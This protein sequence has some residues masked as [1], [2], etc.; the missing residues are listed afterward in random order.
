MSIWGHTSK[1]LLL[2]LVP[3]IAISYYAIWGPGGSPDRVGSAVVTVLGIIVGLMSWAASLVFAILSV[4]KR[5]S[6]A[7]RTLTINIVA[8]VLALVSFGVALVFGFG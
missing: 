2:P 1:I 6:G 7:K 3:C 5:E 4:R 8:L